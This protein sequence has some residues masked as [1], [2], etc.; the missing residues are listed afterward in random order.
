LP[1]ATDKDA[2]DFLS[3]FFYDKDGKELSWIFKSDNQLTLKPVEVTETTTYNIAY[4]YQDSD[5]ERSGST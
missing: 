1:S 3:F 5:Y 4:G 2:G